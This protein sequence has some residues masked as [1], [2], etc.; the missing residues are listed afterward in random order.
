MAQR[1]FVELLLFLTPFMVFL[2]YRAASREMMI[3]DRWPLTTLVVI[4]TVIAVLGLVI[5]PLLEPSEQGKCYQAAQY[6]DG[7]TI[8][9][10]EIPCE[11]A[12]PPGQQ[13]DPNDTQRPAPV[14][15]RDQGG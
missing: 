12:T 11:Q 13:A 15:P 9:A 8:P 4:G 10:K 3:R 5:P 7:K 2:V 14:A 6:I 1:V